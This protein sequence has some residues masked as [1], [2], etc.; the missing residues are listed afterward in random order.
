MKA[1]LVL[2]T[3]PLLIVINAFAQSTVHIEIYAGNSYDQQS[4]SWPPTTSTWDW[5]GKADDGN[6]GDFARLHWYG[7]DGVLT[8]VDHQFGAFDDITQTNT[9]VQADPTQNHDGKLYFDWTS[10]GIVIAKADFFRH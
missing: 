9:T 7:S 6:Q 4:Y 10:Q 5:H 8:V 2:F 3:L 1:I